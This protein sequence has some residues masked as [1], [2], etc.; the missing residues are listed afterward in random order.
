MKFWWLVL[1]PFLFSSVL[2]ILFSFSSFSWISIFSFLLSLSSIFLSLLIWIPCMLLLS[3][4]S[5]PLFC[6]SFIFSLFVSILFKLFSFKLLLLNIESSE[7]FTKNIDWKFIFSLSILSCKS[8]WNF[9]SFCFL[10]ISLIK[11]D[12]FSDFLYIVL[13]ESFDLFWFLFSIFSSCIKVNSLSLI[14]PISLVFLS[15]VVSEFSL[16]ISLDIIFL[17][18]FSFLS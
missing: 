15:F 4:I 6:L 12:F 16:E 8:C 11:S 10:F 3:V 2:N 13:I 9:N 18:S 5:F 17:G 7:L 1:I 14:N